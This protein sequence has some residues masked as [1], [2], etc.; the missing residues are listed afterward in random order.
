MISR[1]IFVTA[2]TCVFL[3]ADIGH[4][5][6]ILSIDLRR[7]KEIPYSVPSRS[8]NYGFGLDKQGSI[9]GRSKNFYQIWDSHS[10][11]PSAFLTSLFRSNLWCCRAYP[12]ATYAGYVIRMAEM[13]NARTIFI[14]NILKGVEGGDQMG[15]L[16]NQVT[17]RSQSMSNRQWCKRAVRHCSHV[18]LSIYEYVPFL[19]CPYCPIHRGARTH[20]HLLSWC[21]NLPTC[22]KQIFEF[23]F[24]STES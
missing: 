7:V 9:L 2:I 20:A 24:Y 19:Y 6:V 14:K 22:S 18:V 11:L 16:K 8:T 5:S 21:S 17:F 15:K 3:E 23:L 10:L 12:T 13:R 4:L 1:L